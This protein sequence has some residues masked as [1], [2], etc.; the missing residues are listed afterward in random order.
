MGQLLAGRVVR[1]LM[2]STAWDSTV[3]FITY[4]EGGGYF[5]HVAPPTASIETDSV[6]GDPVG[7]AFRVPLM[8][9]SP[10]SRPGH[11]FTE[12]VDH[13]SILQ[14]IERTF[15]L[16]QTLPIAS[17]RRTQLADLEDA[18][19]TTVHFPQPDLPDPAQLFD[20]ANETV[21]STDVHRGVLECSTTVP[22]WLP[23]LLGQQ[24][25]TPYPYPTPQ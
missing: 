4:D 15:N 10:Y 14:F 21:L 23:P 16:P 13:T 3:L 20:L 25:L 6:T 11:V 7:P 12:P 2:E 22:R 17:S 8:V 1:S 24:P 5:D 18:L 9:V 19:D